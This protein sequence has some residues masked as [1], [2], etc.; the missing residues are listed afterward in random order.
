MAHFYRLPI[1][2]T[3]EMTDSKVPDIQAGYEKAMISLLVGLSGANLIHD[4]AGFLESA[5]TYSYE[6]LVI[7]NEIPGMCNRAIRGI[8][9]NDE[10]LALDVIEKVGP[11]GHYLTQK[12]T[13][14]HVMTEYYLPKT[15]R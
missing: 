11:G 5:L 13:L 8:E 4:A 9:V 2:A 10:T 1:Y 14:K 12:H 7:D 15:Q 3:G 6:Q